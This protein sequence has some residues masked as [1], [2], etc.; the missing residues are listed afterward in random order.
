MIR[1]WIRFLV[2]FLY[3]FPSLSK[4]EEERKREKGVGR[5]RKENTLEN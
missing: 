5:K 1:K 4:E 3:S 2:I